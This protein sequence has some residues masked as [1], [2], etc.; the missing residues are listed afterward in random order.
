MC[1]SQLANHLVCGDGHH[2]K[3]H[4]Q[5]QTRGTT[6][7]WPRPCPQ[8]AP[9][10][11]HLL[12]Q[13]LRHTHA[14]TI[15]HTLPLTINTTQHCLVTCSSRHTHIHT[16]QKQPVLL[17]HTVHLRVSVGVSAF[18]CQPLLLNPHPTLPIPHV[19]HSSTAHLSSVWAERR[20]ERME[21]EKPRRQTEGGAVRLFED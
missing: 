21:E 16:Q 11:P 17:S 4:I 18:A 10:P 15:T 6:Q 7:M 9:H 12:S 3:W 13:M 8:N 5:R 19:S 1:V 14:H 2:A 20:R